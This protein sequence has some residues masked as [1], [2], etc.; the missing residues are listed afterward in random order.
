MDFVTGSPKSTKHNESIMVV[1]DKLS[2]DAHY[3][4][5]KSTFKEIDISSIFMKYIFRMHSMPKEI[6]SD[7]DTKFT[8]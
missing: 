3:I 2:K 1:V 6:I 8:S 5:I 7:G 4:P